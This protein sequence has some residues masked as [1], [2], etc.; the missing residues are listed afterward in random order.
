VV[1]TSGDGDRTVVF[2]DRDDGVPVPANDDE[3][4][5]D[6]VGV[7]MR[8]EHVL[9]SCAIPVLFPAVP[10]CKPS[11]S[12]GRCLDGGMRLNAPIKPALA[13]EA[14][15][16]IVVA[17]H[18]MRD[19][20]TTPHPGGLASDVDDILVEFLDIVLVDRMVED[21]RT[22]AKINALM[23]EDGAIATVT[24]RLRKKV[25]YVRRSGSS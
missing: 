8:P 9:A 4:P 6:Y 23:P 11:G 22:L 2:V 19:T 16:L 7:R 12:A 24:G 1:T 3:R 17:T 25:P 15:A 18:P 20:T 10:L 14:D 13:L 5:I 21:L